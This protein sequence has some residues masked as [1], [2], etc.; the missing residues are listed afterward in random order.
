MKICPDCHNN[1]D[2]YE[3]HAQACAWVSESRD[4]VPIYLSS[5]DKADTM[6]KSYLENYHEISVDDLEESI[7]HETYLQ[8]QNEE[9]FS[10]IPNV[11]GLNVCEIGVGKGLLLQHLIKKEP[12]TLTGI[13]ISL[14]YLN[15]IGKKLG[16][17]V[18]LIVANAENIPFVHEFDV[19]IAADIIEHV[20]NVGDFLTSVNR[21]LKPNGRFIVK[22]PNNE[23]INGYSTLRGCKYNFVHLR[24]FNKQTLST[25]L[26]GAGFEV[27]KFIFDGFY[28]SKKRNYLKRSSFLANKFDQFINTKFKSVHDVNKT[29]NFICQ[30]FMEPI[31]I[32]ACASKKRDVLPFHNTNE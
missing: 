26:N 6:F 32:T 31:E 24:S 23:D 10:Y 12:A 4:G 9:L 17:D 28:P 5:K 30:L 3:E 7:Q 29:H 25:V 18:N 13:D 22:T 15:V 11:Q 1:I 2:T 19:I 14:P 27:Q 16:S 21:A 20:F 8:S